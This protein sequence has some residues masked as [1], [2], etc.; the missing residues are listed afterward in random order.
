MRMEP[1]PSLPWARAP[2]RRPLPPRSPTGAA[3][4]SR[5]IPG[6]LVGPNSSGSVTG[7]NPYS[8]VLV[9]P[10]MTTPAVLNL[11]TNS[12]SWSGTKSR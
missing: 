5:Q 9:L 6:F 3:R 8:G 10:M 7:S 1:P 12:L 2:C 4:G 11:L